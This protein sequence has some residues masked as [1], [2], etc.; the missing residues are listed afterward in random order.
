MFPLGMNTDACLRAPVTFVQDGF[1]GF[2]SDL[3]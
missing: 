1:N 2:I 3:G